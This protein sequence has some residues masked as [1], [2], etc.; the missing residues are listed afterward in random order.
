LRRLDR[1]SLVERTP[2]LLDTL[3][4]SA[5]VLR[6]PRPQKVK[7]FVAKPPPVNI[8]F[9]NTTQPD[10]ETLV[11]IRIAAMRESLERIG[12]FDPQRARER[13]LSTFDPAL[14][15]FITVDGV[16]VGF[17]VIHPEAD[18]WLLDHF[19]I[20]PEHQ[21][22][23]IGAAVLQ[24]VFAN[25]DAQSMPIRLGAL[26]GSDSNRFYQ[27]H[28]FVQTDE[29]EWDIYYVRQPNPPKVEE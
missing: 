23:G 18:H 12:R 13:F 11:A 29:A 5:I 9:P 17:I 21:G 3:R 20:L 14:C 27:R 8:A 19:Y 28:G 25:A 10:A 4:L 6:T 26:R 15:R 1:Q 22:K 7:P 24:D 16:R 2:E